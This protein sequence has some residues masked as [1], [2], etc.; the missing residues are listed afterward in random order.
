MIDQLKPLIGKLTIFAKDRMGF[1]HPPRLFLKSDS[2]NSKKMLGKTAYYD[3]QEKAITLFT[4][5]RHPKDILR[6]Y[7]HELVHHTQNL[8]GDLSPEKC[9]EMGDGYAQ[10]NGH[11]R[12]MEREAYEKGNMCFRDWEDTLKDKD[13][14]IIIKIAESKNLKENK[15]MTKKITKEF[16]KETIRKILSESSPRGARVKVKDFSKGQELDKS[17]NQQTRAIKIFGTIEAAQAAAKKY[18]SIE[19][20]IAASQPDSSTVAS[21]G[22]NEELSEAPVAGQDGVPTPQQTLDALKQ[23]LSANKKKA[24]AQKKVGRKASGGRIERKRRIQNKLIQKHF[25]E[26]NLMDVQAGLLKLGYY[27][28]V[29]PEDLE[30]TVDGKY[31][32]NTEKAIMAFQKD[33]KTNK[34]IAAD[35]LAGPTFLKA[36]SRVISSPESNTKSGKKLDLADM[37]YLADKVYEKIPTAF[38]MRDDGS[39][40]KMGTSS[41]DNVTTAVPSS[42]VK[43][44]YAGQKLG[45]LDDMPGAGGDEMSR[46]EKLLSKGGTFM[47]PSPIGRMGG[48][49]PPKTDAEK[50]DEK[51]ARRL[52]L[53][54]EENEEIEEASQEEFAK[55]RPPYNKATAAD[56]AGDDGKPKNESKIQTPEQEN[57]LYEQ[58][59]SKKNTK[60]FEKL[61]KEWT[62]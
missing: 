3:P 21:L 22:V 1:Q 10:T 55:N 19:K 50:E 52:S 24:A 44:P 12:E 60:L 39:R 20:A 58:R 30:R 15:S 45:S 4:H 48:N 6:S 11:M 35:G 56:R 36:L 61:L 34:P 26:L 59:F 31:G 42:K 51:R 43:D 53:E 62:K 28:N 25:G 27:G 9:G 54:E 5:N 17:E 2:N 18:G 16:L 40:V 32:D 8:R 23:G 46:R 33:V 37:E 38:R 47:E 14:Y 41:I 57:T 7:A 13:I 29:Q 49:L